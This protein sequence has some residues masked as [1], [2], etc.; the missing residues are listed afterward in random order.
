MERSGFDGMV[1]T[2][3]SLLALVESGRIDGDQAVA[4]S[5]KP[6]EL[7]QA[8]LAEADQPP[9]NTRTKRTTA[10]PAE[11]PIIARRPFQISAC[12]VKPR[13][14]AFSSSGSTGSGASGLVSGW[15]TTQRPNSAFKPKRLT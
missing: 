11:R 14:Q 4:V 15:S 1:T 12:G 2:N 7:A 13:F 8:L 5:L 6:N 9:L 10:I 3:Q